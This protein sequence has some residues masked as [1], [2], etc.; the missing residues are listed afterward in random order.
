VPGNQPRLWIDMTSFAVLGR[1]RRTYRFLKDTRLG[2]TVILETAKLDAMADTVTHYVAE[3]IIERER[4]MEGDW[5]I[6]RVMRDEVTRR[7]EA[8]AAVADAIKPRSGPA[9]NDRSN[10]GWV[11]AAFLGGILIGAIVLFAYAW[12]AVG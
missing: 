11:I 12:V 4:A 5:L 8:R 6:K 3:R 9:P 10:L 1:D 2:R 7:N